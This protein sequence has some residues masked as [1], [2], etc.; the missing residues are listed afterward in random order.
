MHEAH[1]YRRQFNEHV[2]A[3]YAAKLNVLFIA[4]ARR[5]AFRL[6]RGA[7]Q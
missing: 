5:R 1:D 7:C 4:A 2:A 6:V 3:Y